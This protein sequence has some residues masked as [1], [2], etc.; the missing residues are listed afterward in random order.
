MSEGPAK[1]SWKRLILR[2]TVVGL[3]LVLALSAVEITLWWTLPSYHSVT[4][5]PHMIQQHTD[6]AGFK[7]D[8][9]L[10][11]YWKAV[12][13][14]GVGINAHGFRRQEAMT[15]QKPPGITR[16]IVFGDSQTHGGGVEVNETFSYYAEQKLGDQWE[17]LNAGMSGY[18]SLNIYRMMR[19]LMLPFEADI[20]IV[21]CMAFDSPAE[22][23]RLHQEA[24]GSWQLRLR[25]ATWNSRLNF[26]LQLAL[27]RAGVGVWED[28]PWP[29]HLHK[30]REELVGKRQRKHGL[31]N[32][33]Q[34]GRWASERGIQVV[35]MEYPYR[36]RGNLIDCQA[37]AHELPDGYPIFPSCSVLQSAEVPPEKLFIDSNHLTPL[38]NQVLGA[39]LADFLAELEQ[40]P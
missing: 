22:D 4:L 32:H 18:R 35:F 1:I 34:I 27:R 2:L 37:H 23:G 30:V 20:F 13:I 40:A 10:M 5:P 9:D 39:A 31:G 3:V 8:P 6:E 15:Q 11:W 29:I 25:E 36:T 26:L 28:L 38:G 14:P 12:P 19:K 7:Y 24:Q 17:L 33:D 16:A 21:N